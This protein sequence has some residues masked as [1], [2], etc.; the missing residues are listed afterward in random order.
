MAAPPPPPPSAKRGL[1]GNPWVGNPPH[2][3]DLRIAWAHSWNTWTGKRDGVE[4][5]PM[6]W[7]WIGGKYPNDRTDYWEQ[8]NKTVPLGYAGD[9]LFVN[10]PEMASQSRLSPLKAAT[11]FRMAV[12]N[13]DD[14]RWSSPQVS[15]GADGAWPW[16]ARWWAALP[17]SARERLGFWAVH[18]YANDVALHTATVERWVDWLYSMKAVPLWVTEWGIQGGAYEDGGEDAVAELA[19]WYDRHEAIE[20]HAYFSN[21]LPRDQWWAAPFADMALV[22]AGGITARGRGWLRHGI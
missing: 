7:G 13:Y 15:I 20:R 11:Y 1:A 16:M 19:A 18:L 12:G 6:L 14:A 21:W 3:A 8:F 9:V 2:G 22:E 5:V 17:D 4:L 10:E